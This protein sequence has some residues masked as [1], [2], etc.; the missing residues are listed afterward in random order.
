MAVKFQNHSLCVGLKKGPNGVDC[1]GGEWDGKDA[2]CHAKRG[3]LEPIIAWRKAMCVVPDWSATFF[4]ITVRFPGVPQRVMGDEAPS[5]VNY[6]AASGCIPAACRDVVSHYPFI[7]VKRNVN[8][9][10][11]RVVRSQDRQ[12]GREAVR[13]W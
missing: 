6:M 7:R 5:A 4:E 13:P 3:P 11:D 8:A 12:P 9:R 10:G 2:S 1:G